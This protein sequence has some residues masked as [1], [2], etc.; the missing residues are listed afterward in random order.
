MMSFSGME[1]F[2]VSAQR[3]GPQVVVVVVVVDNC[4][5]LTVPHTRFSNIKGAVAPIL[6]GSVQWLKDFYLSG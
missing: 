6:K 5:V 2:T 1:R 4:Y 3:E